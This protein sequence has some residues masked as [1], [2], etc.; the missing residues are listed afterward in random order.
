VGLKEVLISI[1]ILSALLSSTQLTASQLD[2][3]SAGAKGNN[4]SGESNIP[5]PNT[6]FA[7]PAA[8]GVHNVW[9]TNGVG[10][11]NVPEP[12]LRGD[13]FERRK[14][15]LKSQR[16]EPNSP[17]YVEKVSKKIQELIDA[18]ELDE[19]RIKS[20]PQIPLTGMRDYEFRS[21]ILE[22]ATKEERLLSE[23]VNNYK[24]II[25]LAEKYPDLGVNVMYM[26][27]KL[28]KC[29][30]RREEVELQKKSLQE[31]YQRQR[32]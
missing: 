28:I 30:G 32:R 8:A 16:T 26:K 17:E 24:Q 21:K 23:E 12:N 29:Q 19:I 7:T 3:I 22:N 25:Q 27:K 6:G 10:Q 5:E 15:R 31:F 1:I 9:E 13:I 20:L 4:S 11:C 14:N 2:K 18:I